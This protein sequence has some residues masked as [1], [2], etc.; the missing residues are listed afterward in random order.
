MEVER[1]WMIVKLW[2]PGGQISAL[3]WIHELLTI[4]QEHYWILEYESKCS[5]WLAFWEVLW[6]KFDFTSVVT[7][8]LILQVNLFFKLWRTS[9]TYAHFYTLNSVVCSLFTGLLSEGLPTNEMFS[10]FNFPPWWKQIHV[11][12]LPFVCLCSSCFRVFGLNFMFLV[13]AISIQVASGLQ[14]GKDFIW[15]TQCGYRRESSIAP[16]KGLYLK[17]KE[18]SLQRLKTHSQYCQTSGEHSLCWWN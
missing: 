8:T 1:I 5:T 11:C 4:K 3:L 16:L 10:S 2:R 14:I 18:G 9:T 17:S 7:Q 13:C 6:F 12:R 15:T